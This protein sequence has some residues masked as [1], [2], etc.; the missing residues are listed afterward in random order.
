MKNAHAVL[1]VS[2]GATADDIRKAYK[3]L[4]KTHHPDRN[5]GSQDASDRM[6]TIIAAYGHLTDLTK[7]S[8]ARVQAAHPAQRQDAPRPRD[9]DA[10][11]EKPRPSPFTR[12]QNR[13]AARGASMF[14]RARQDTPKS[15]LDADVAAMDR[16]AENARLRAAMTGRD[17]HAAAQEASIKELRARE[18]EEPNFKMRSFDKEQRIR[19]EAL[20]RARANFAPEQRDTTSAH[21]STQPLL[22]DPSSMFSRHRRVS[23]FVMTD[24]Q[25]T[26]M[27]DALK[28][29][30][31]ME[32]RASMQRHRSG[33]AEA[34]AALPAMHAA[35]K[36]SFEG[37]KM[38]I[39]MGS[40]GQ[41]GRNFVAIPDLTQ[42]DAS[43]VR[44]D[45][46]IR[47]VEVIL[48]KDGKQS[49]AADASS[50]LVKNGRNI[51]INID[52]SEQRENLR[53]AHLKRTASR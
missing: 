27:Q 33:I 38:S 49:I 53:D 4:A 12:F 8:A 29:Q 3:D 9:F 11:P 44:M 26:K 22:G 7:H 37:R 36:I 35:Q 52:F 30:A 39:Q 1:G 47:L 41:T 5:H 23:E 17:P 34:D 25:M 16:A 15:S 14:A 24:A 13:D 45:K 40:R 48:D 32:A 19:D 28:S 10:R 18:T 20:H 51:Q 21:D 2:P 46:G 42:S 31:Q 50:G 43:T 6:A